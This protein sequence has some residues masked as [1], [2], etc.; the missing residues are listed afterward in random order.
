MF[1]TVYTLR[2]GTEFYGGF[3]ESAWLS[4]ARRLIAN[5]VIPNSTLF[6][7]LLILFQAAAAIAILTR[8]DLVTVALLAGGAFSLIV[9]LFS[10][11][12]GTAANLALAVIQ[13]ALAL[14]R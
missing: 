9:A 12:A 8:G 1:N 13:F 7:V 4:P 3:A 6:T 14:S 10:S 5:V 2:H 11:P